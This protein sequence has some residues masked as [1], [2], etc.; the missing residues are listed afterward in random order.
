[1][2]LVEEPFYHVIQRIM[3]CQKS[4]D[5]ACN[6]IDT[7][8]V[9]NAF[10]YWN[11]AYFEWHK[12]P[13]QASFRINRHLHSRS[14]S[15]EIY[16]VY[17]PKARFMNF[18]W[19]DYSYKILCI[20]VIKVLNK[21]GFTR[22]H[23]LHYVP[24]N[25]FSLFSVAMRLCLDDICYTIDLCHATYGFGVFTRWH[26]LNDICVMHHSVSPCKQALSL[27]LPWRFL[28][29]YLKFCFESYHYYLVYL[30]KVDL[31]GDTIMLHDKCVGHVADNISALQNWMFWEWIIDWHNQTFLLY[32]CQYLT[33]NS[34]WAWHTLYAML[35]SN[36]KWDNC[37][38]LLP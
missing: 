15:Y 36:H 10:S 28:I 14:F 31:H 1:M 38:Y 16:E 30:S 25:Q 33:Y 4:Y 19:N 12:I 20:L 6:V 8:R 5:H 23:M 9:S 32:E 2:A 22:I 18:I 24:C 27:W 26:F 17:S 37:I 35:T 7:V 34:R 11:N 21:G 13:F 3:S 29:F